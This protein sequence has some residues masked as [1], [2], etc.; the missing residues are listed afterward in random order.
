M[1]VRMN[2]WIAA[3]AARVRK[4]HSC[5]NFAALVEFK[6]VIKILGMKY[7]PDRTMPKSK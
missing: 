2:N 1:R 6:A 7:G 5:A 4:I 3:T